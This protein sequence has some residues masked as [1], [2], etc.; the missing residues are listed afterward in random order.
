MQFGI[1][2]VLLLNYRTESGRD[3]VKT[4][5][6]VTSQDH[7]AVACG[8]VKNSGLGLLASHTLPRCGTDV[9]CRSPRLN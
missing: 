9:T 1:R 4:Q 7:N 5:Q 3:G 6:S 2:A 8:S